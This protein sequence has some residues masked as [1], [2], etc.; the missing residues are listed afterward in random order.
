MKYRHAKDSELDKVCDLLAEGF[1]NDPVHEV[2]F[3][4][5]E[6]R[7]KLLR[8]YLR[9]YVEIAGKYGGTLIAGDIEGVLVYFRPEAMNLRNKELTVIDDQIREVCG[10]YYPQVA[11]YTYGLEHHHPRTPPHFYIPLLAVQRSSC[12]R[13]V[14]SGLLNMLNDIVDKDHM[15]CYAECTRLSTRN[16]L[17]RWGYHDSGPALRIEGIPELFPVWREPQ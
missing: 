13:G 3:T 9:I 11:V 4:D 7:I 12:G 14:A 16:L 1:N 17:M 6:C 5:P 10:S 2:L 15:P 8:N